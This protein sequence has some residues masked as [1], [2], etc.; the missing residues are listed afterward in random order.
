MANLPRISAAH[1]FLFAA[2]IIYALAGTPTPDQPGTIEI[3]IG[4]LLL[5]SVLC[6]GIARIADVGLGS[7]LF[8]KSVQIFFLCGLI[9]PTVTAVYFANDHMLILRDLAAFCFLG[10]PLFLA[11]TFSNRVRESNILI[12][13]CVFAGLSFCIRTLMPVFNVWAPAGE[14]LYLSNS[15]LAMFAG[16]ALVCAGWSQLLLLRIRNVF[17]AALCFGG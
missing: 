16:I 15:P 6:G 7:G 12:G 2:I 3:I 10:L 11:G 4:A 14:L 5:L 13:L 1:V 9:V 8:L 17:I